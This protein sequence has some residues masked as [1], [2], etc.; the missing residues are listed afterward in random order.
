MVVSQ[1]AVGE[2]I[3]SW[4]AADG[5]TTFSDRPPFDTTDV[6][7]IKSSKPTSSPVGSEL[8]EE[9][10]SDKTHP[11][12]P[13]NSTQRDLPFVCEPVTPIER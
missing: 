5:S 10:L 13:A 6:T 1:C 9:W 4:Q 3:F 7:I 2:T 11:K 12:T 8:I